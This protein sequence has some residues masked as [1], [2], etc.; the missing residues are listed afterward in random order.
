MPTIKWLPQWPQR[1]HSPAGLLR[2]ARRETT[3]GKGCSLWVRCNMDKRIKRIRPCTRHSQRRI[4]T[5]LSSLCQ[6]IWCI[7]S[8]RTSLL[9][10]FCRAPTSMTR[11][12]ST[13]AWPIWTTRGASSSQ[14]VRPQCTP[15][16]SETACRVMDPMWWICQ[17]N[18]LLMKTF[19][20]VV[21]SS[22]VIPNHQCTGSNPPNTKVHKVT[23]PKFKSSTQGNLD[24]SNKWSTI[25]RKRSLQNQSAWMLIKIEYIDK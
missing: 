7:S 10:S 17:N 1:R 16:N 12:S 15:P 19:N 8:S 21:K 20:R 11:M 13:T 18:N 6:A 14:R 23:T 2:K 4:F 9:G 3:K 25:I 24:N 5:P 22:R